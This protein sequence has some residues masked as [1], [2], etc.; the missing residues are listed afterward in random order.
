MSNGATKPWSIPRGIM[1]LP[2]ATFDKGRKLD[3][4]TNARLIEFEIK[5]GATSICILM[6][7]AEQLNLSMQERKDLTEQSVKAVAGRVPVLVHVSLSGTDHV[8]ELTQHAEKA[9]ADA[10]VA[11][12]PYYWKPTQ[13]QI[14][15]HFAAIMSSTGLPFVGYHSPAFMDGIGITPATLLRLVERFPTQCIGL[16]E[17]SHNFEQFIELRRAGQSINP[18]FGV[19]TGIEYIIPAMTLGG[20]GSMSIFGGVA[21]RLVQKLYD[22]TVQGSLTEALKL[23]DKVSAL[24]QLGKGG[25]PAPIKTMMEIMGRPVGETRLPLIPTS[26]EKKAFLEKELDKLG[27][28]QSE[29]HGW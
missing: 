25:Y 16:K 22:L 26:P 14:Y 10:V 20:V 7:L 19:I 23:Q 13:D 28:L 2:V 21:P 3:F 8:I 9:G 12:A 6:H 15:E 17:A 1:H 4:D 18:D 27:I 29:P 5:H 11:I 24:W